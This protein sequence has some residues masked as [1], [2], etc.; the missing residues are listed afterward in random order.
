MVGEGEWVKNVRAAG[1]EAYLISGQRRKVMLEEV[2]V[3]HRAPIIKEYLRL[4]PGGRPHIGLGPTAPIVDYERVAPNYPV[5]R[6][7]YQDT[8]APFAGK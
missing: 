8:P 1:G 3:E 6:I 2:P 4:A 7:V 5:F